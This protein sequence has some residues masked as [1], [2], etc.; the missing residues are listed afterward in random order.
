MIDFGPQKGPTSVARIQ[1]QQRQLERELMSINI[2]E[3]LA[4][5]LLWEDEADEYKVIERSD[6]KQSAATDWQ[7]KFVIFTKDNINFYRLSVSRTGSDY[8]DWT[9]VYHSP[10]YQVDKVE[11][12]VYEWKRKYVK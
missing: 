1:A 4:H 10:C 12:V 7:D 3:E 6:W 2:D 11:K 5:L 8:T 9:Y